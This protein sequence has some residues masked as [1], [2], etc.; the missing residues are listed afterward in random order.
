MAR[1]KK[2]L[3]SRRATFQAAL[4]IIDEE[5]LEALSIRRLGREL[6]VQGISLYHHFQNKEE[7]LVGA[8]QLAL[9]TVRTPKATDSNWR[10]WLLQNTLNYRKA[11]SEHPN[12]IP[13]LMRR[14]PL[15]IGLG[16]HN[17]TAG[18]LAAQGIPLGAIMPLMEALEEI[19]LGSA[20]YQSAVDKDDQSES[21]KQDFPVLYHLSRNPVPRERLFTLMASAV[22]DAIAK[23]YRI[24]QHKPSPIQLAATGT[25]DLPKPSRAKSLPSKSTSR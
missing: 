19:V 1:P 2:P 24:E 4:K 13:V 6:K 11:L 16:E 14:H 20:N 5:G 22:I 10:E 9:A 12:L 3:I 7:I 23:E 18:L 8:C 15:R 17:A 21:W 25:H